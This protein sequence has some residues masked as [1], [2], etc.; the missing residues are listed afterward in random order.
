MA[1]T[2]KDTAFV[3]SSYAGDVERFALLCETMDR[4]ASGWTRHLVLVASKDVAL[5]RQFSGPKREIVDEADI[6]PR[7]LKR[8]PDPI[9]RGRRDI[10]INPTLLPPVWPMRGWHVQQLRRIAIAGF[11]NEAAYVSCDSDVAFVA[12]YDVQSNWRGNDMRLYCLEKALDAPEMGEQRNWSAIAGKRL[13]LAHTSGTA[14]YVST[15][16]Q[17]RV[18]DVRGMMAHIEAIAGRHWVSAIGSDRTFSECM[19]YGRYI[20]DVRAS[21]NH[22]HSA[23]ALCKVYWKGPTLDRAGITAFAA[24]RAPGQVAVGLQS[25][26]GTP[27][28]EI[29]AA[30][31]DL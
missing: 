29:R 3:T 6:L 23:E 11:I 18:A 12:P 16:I 20:D 26:V 4:F 14:D 28:S 1:D 13:G 19:I 27:V 8:F 10:W 22:F 17:W 30:L 21:A 5:F 7:W 2:S 15:L 25:F 24:D 31:A 9:S